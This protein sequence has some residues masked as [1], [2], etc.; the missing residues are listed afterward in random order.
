MRAKSL[1]LCLTLHDPLDYGPPG[2]SVLGIPQTR[3]LEW[4]VMPSSQGFPNPRIK[5]TSRISPAVA[6]GVFTR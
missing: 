6:G 3:L 2:F 1:Q 5:P 4:V